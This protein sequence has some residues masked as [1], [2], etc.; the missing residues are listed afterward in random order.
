M[1]PA[2]HSR[3]YIPS[4]DGWRA[5][6]ILIVL[7]DHCETLSNP[8]LRHLQGHGMAGVWLF[9]AI[10]GLLICSRMLDEESSRGRISLRRFYQRRAFRI[11]PA[12]FTY[13]CLL[14]VLGA[15]NILPFDLPAWT[16]S[17]FFYRNYWHFFHGAPPQ[18]WFS[19]HFWSLSVEE[20][21]YLLLPVIMVFLPRWRK[22]AL[23][24]LVLVSS[25]WLVWYAMHAP[26]TTHHVFF[27]QRTE[28]CLCA[29]LVPALLAM[30]LRSTRFKR[31]AVM[32]LPPWVGILCGAVTLIGFQ[33]SRPDMYWAQTALLRSVFFPLMVLSTVLHP[34]S[35]LTGLLE[36]RPVRFIGRISYSLYL[37]HALFLTR[38][39]QFRGPLH[40]LQH[41]VVGMAC[42]LGCAVVSYYVI[43][44]PFVRLG[45]RVAT[46]VRNSV[47]SELVPDA[48][49]RPTR[50]EPVTTLSG[51]EKVRVGHH[52]V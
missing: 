24:L 50:V 10:S 29:L 22:Y 32:V 40:R 15:A 16:A 23:S 37:W 35:W 20:H 27:E 45:A 52:V 13:L 2:E 4:L 11:L 14:A 33:F 34:E 21:F 49:V 6:A 38:D 42:S 12:A 9:F 26:H 3:A 17:A 1:R 31:Y 7:L 51:V 47:P 44:R 28:F 43:E 46:G 19:S 18:A 8:V 36:L 5:V 25:G 30:W 48:S 39:L 41:P